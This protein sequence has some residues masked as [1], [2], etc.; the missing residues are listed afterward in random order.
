MAGTE[1]T[2]PRKVSSCEDTRALHKGST[3]GQYTRAVHKG[4]TQ[5]STQ[6]NTKDNTKLHHGGK[7]EGKGEGAHAREKACKGEGAHV[8]PT[9]VLRSSVLLLLSLPMLFFGNLA[10]LNSLETAS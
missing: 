10:L 8:T 4:S 7:G 3:Q 1:S 2:W 9:L 6:D 5:I